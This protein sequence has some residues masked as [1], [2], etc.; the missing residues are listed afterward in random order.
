MIAIYND[1]RSGSPHPHPQYSAI[2]LRRSVSF[3]LQLRRRNGLSTICAMKSPLCEDGGLVHGIGRGIPL[4]A[5]F[6]SILPSTVKLC[7]P[8]NAGLKLFAYT[9]RTWRI[10]FWSVPAADS[11]CSVI[12]SRGSTEKS[13]LAYP[14]HKAGYANIM[15]HKH[16][17]P[18]YL[19]KLETIP[20]P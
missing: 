6:R 8:D 16:S 9:L 4:S 20:L 18:H 11:R 12:Q 1:S 14:Q 15:H 3:Q 17:P 7:I 5:V 2:G 10:C 19:L 13:S